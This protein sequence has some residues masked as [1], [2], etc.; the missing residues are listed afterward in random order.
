MRARVLDTRAARA[1]V[2]G[3]QGPLIVEEGDTTVVVPPGWRADIDERGF[4][5]LKRGDDR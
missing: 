4:I 2:G 5:S 1:A 3:A